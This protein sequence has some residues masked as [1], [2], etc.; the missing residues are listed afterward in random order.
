MPQISTILM[1]LLLSLTGF[2]AN[3]GVPTMATKV[4]SEQSE[5]SSLRMDADCMHK[6][7]NLSR[8][9]MPCCDHGH[10]Q[11][12]PDDM[13]CGMACASMCTSPVFLITSSYFAY[14]HTRHD[15]FAGAGASFQ[16]H[17][18]AMTLP[19]PRA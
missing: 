15:V 17:K 6:K 2:A 18:S 9:H 14:E 5:M 8:Q 12:C 19:P 13:D 16:P 3:A 11:N 1:I 4:A 10:G 7:G